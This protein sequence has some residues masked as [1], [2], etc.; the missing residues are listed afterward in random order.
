ML[1]HR[2]K[3]HKMLLLL[4]LNAFLVACTAEGNSAAE[5]EYTEADSYNGVDIG[6]SEEEAS[7][8]L[9]GYESDGSS[10]DYGEDENIEREPFDED[11]AREAA[12]AEV[13]SGSYTGIGSPYG[14]TIDCSGHEAG[15]AWRR[16]NGYVTSGYSQSFHEG[17]QA[18]E[19][20]VEER[21]EEMRENYDSGLDPEY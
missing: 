17:A 5:D 16:D 18:F 3:A 9:T 10:G 19:D 6:E 8:S 15:F 12:E 7:Y 21:V 4:A 2:A 11:A 20:T 14:C 13:A 1:K